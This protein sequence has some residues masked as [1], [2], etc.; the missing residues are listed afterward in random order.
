MGF[1]LGAIGYISVDNFANFVHR[2]A[3]FIAYNQ[4]YAVLNIVGI[5]IVTNGIRIRTGVI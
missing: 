1:V 5:I 2:V 4:N 3:P